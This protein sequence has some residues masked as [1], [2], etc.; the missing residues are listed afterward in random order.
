VAL[1]VAL[2]GC[3]GRRSERPQPPPAF[4]IQVTDDEGMAVTLPRRPARIVSVAPHFTETLL[5]LGLGDRVIAVSGAETY[6]PEALTI[7]SVLPDGSF[8]PDPAALEALRPDLVLASGGPGAPWKAASRDRGLAIV[9]LN[10]ATVAEALD[11]VRT[12][13]RLTGTA[14]TASRLT[15]RIQEELDD[16][17]AAVGRQSPPSLFLEVGPRFPPL[18]GAGPSSL[19]G[20]LARLAGGRLVT[21]GEQAPYPEWPV[22]RLTQADP[23]VYVVTS[24]TIASLD[25]LHARP[26]FRRL[27]AVQGGRTGIVDDE[28]VL[29]PGPRLAEGARALA[30]LLHPDAGL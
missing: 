6:P 23:D 22:E 17:R 26:G 24:A 16:L 12:I 27:R 13:G 2:P 3:I 7:P 30:R 4:P 20:E 19:T 15:R 25:E 28:L 29:L 9:T 8:E 11:D 14:T 10:A 5:A 21:D 18:I 1:A